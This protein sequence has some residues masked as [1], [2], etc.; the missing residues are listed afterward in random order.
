MGQ[1]RIGA[2]AVKSVRSTTVVL[3]LAGVALISPAVTSM[4]FAA[5]DPGFSYQGELRLS[6]V[7]IDGDHDF[8]FR[9]YADETGGVAVGPTLSL[10]NVAVADGVFSVFL[11]FGSAALSSQPRFL[12]IDV[13]TAGDAAFQTLAPR[14]RL[15][16]APYAWSAAVALENSVNRAS[17][18]AGSVGSDEID[19]SE[20]QRRVANACP[21]GQFVRQIDQDGTAVCASAGSSGSAWS[22][23]GNAGTDPASDFVGTTDAQAMTIGSNGQAVARFEA[24]PLAAPGEF[25]ANIRMGSPDNVLQPG[26]RGATISGGG[27]PETVPNSFFNPNRVTDDFGTIGGGQANV[28]G[29][30]DGNT[31]NHPWATVGGGVDNFAT[32]EAA[33][34]GGGKTNFVLG[35]HGTVAGGFENFATD[36]GAA[37]GGGEQ[38]RAAGTTSTVS[39]GFN[40]TASGLDSVVA[41]GGFNSATGAQSMVSG[42]EENCA[43][44]QY[45]WAG[46]RR[47]KARPGVVSGDPGFG[48]SGVPL[49]ATGAGDAGT[50]V[51]ADSQ[52]SDFV[53][54]GSNQFLVRASGGIYLG[55][56]STVS[57]PAGR[58]INT[59]TGAF[60]S[61][62]GT[63]TNSSSRALKQGFEAIDPGTVLSR[64]LDLPVMRWVYRDSPEE[65]PHL[66]PIAEDFHAAFGLG[67]DS[68]TI[69]TV[70]ASGV[71]LAAIQGLNQ[72]LEEENE[73]LRQQ[74]AAQDQAI[75]ELRHELEAL[76]QA[77]EQV[78]AE[79]D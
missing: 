58:F 24:V 31:S 41:G 6:G 77:L 27:V 53:S 40:N 14:T 79:V 65:G 7:P 37:I 13:R 57:L 3:L 18:V 11:D 60:L 34:V 26:V 30:D 4:S 45:S 56:N 50:F 68:R 71:A 19:A 51:W 59:S 67:A 8:R 64:L 9:L 20:V 46:G 76:R 1:A 10:A 16:V 17:I 5:L 48:C 25:T 44:G 66:G 74:N 33:T 69:S 42:G 22:L 28:V 2:I 63:W 36:I 23:S 73:A 49:S 70:D 12:E 32:R 61:N 52:S 62:G 43:G 29:N 35:V 55:G 15:S 21:P 75:S 72:R 38:N 54:T 39:G 78:G 47:A